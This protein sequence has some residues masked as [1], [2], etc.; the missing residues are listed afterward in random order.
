MRSTTEQT[1]QYIQLLQQHAG[2]G[3]IY[4]TDAKLSR[5]M[6][7]PIEQVPAILRDLVD[8]GE[9]VPSGTSRHGNQ[10]YTLPLSPEAAELLAAI[11]QEQPVPMARM[12][13]LVGYDK[14][15]YLELKRRGLVGATYID[16]NRYVEVT[17]EVRP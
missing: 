5:W 1:I 15:P 6:R 10:I 3:K 17:G 16:G 2:N 9:L 8:T 12:E 13:D 11:T 7:V 4:R 14:G